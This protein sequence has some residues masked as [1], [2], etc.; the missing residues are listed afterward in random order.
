[1]TPTGTQ[2]ISKQ[3]TLTEGSWSP[4]CLA[5]NGYSYKWFR[6]GAQFQTGTFT[7]SS[8]TYTTQSADIGH[9]LTAQV[10]ACDTQSNCNGATATGSV[11]VSCTPTNSV[12]PTMNHSGNGVINTTLG[13][14]SNG[15][16]TAPCGALSYRYEWFRGS[17]QV[18]TASTYTTASADINSTITLKVQAYNANGSSSYV[19][20]SNT[21]Y[22][23]PAP[24]NTA[25]PTVSGT[26]TVGD[27]LTGN[28]GTWNQYGVSTTVSRQWQIC[29]YRNTVLSD[30]PLDYW[31]LGDAS[32]ASPTARDELELN[33][34]SYVGSPTLGAAP[35]ALNSDA[36]TAVAFNGNSYLS[37]SDP[38]QFGSANFTIEG[39]FKTSS[40]AG[41][42][43]IWESDYAGTPTQPQDVFLGLA[44]GKMMFQVEDQAGTLALV[45]S[46]LSYNNNAWHYV[47][48]VRNGNTFTVYVDG[49]SVGS[50]T[51]T[52]TLGSVDLSGSVPTI[53]DG[54]ST[55][56]NSHGAY[57]FGGS[58]DEVAV[59]QSALSS[60]RVS[61][62][63]NAGVDVTKGCANISGAT[64]S[65]YTLI[66]QDFG[67]KLRF[68]VSESNA[69]GTGPV[70]YSSLTGTVADSAPSTPTITY[71]AAPSGTPV[72]PTDTPVI[73]AS[74]PDSGDSDPVDY[75]FQ[76][77]NTNDPQFLSPLASSG[78]LRGTDN[79]T[80]PHGALSNGGT[81]ILRVQAR[82]PYQ[83]TAWSGQTTFKVSLPMLGSGYWPTWS[84]G[85]VT[86][87]EV[88]GNLM[89][90]LP[91]PSYPTATG[92]LS[93]SLTYN[94]QSSSNSPG[95][96]TGWTLGAGDAAA[97]PPVQLIDHSKDAQDPYPAAEI[98]WPDG[99]TD[100]YSQVGTSDT[101]TPDSKDGS[102]LTQNTDHSG[103]TL[104]A[105]DGT[106]Y[107]FDPATQPPNGVW[108]LTGA[109]TAAA[110]NGYGL[111]TYSFLNGLLHTL[112]YNQQSG[113]NDGETLTFNW[114]CT[115]YVLCVTGP[116]A[117]SGPSWD[118]AETNG[119]LS[120][121]DEVVGGSTH[122]Q[123]ALSYTGA[124][125][126]KIQNANDLDPAD[127]SPGYN[128]QHSLQLTY[129]G[130]KVACVID[131]PISGQAQT[132]QPSCAGG[133]NASESTW[134]FA[135]N[136][137]TSC[138]ALTPP[139][140]T[141]AVP[142]GS[143]NGCTTVTNPDQEPNGPGVT[144][145]YDSDG[146]P[147]ETDDARLGS[148]NQRITL[149]QYNAQNRLAW[150]EDE[151]GNPTDY[152]YD[153][154]N[155]V[156]LTQTAPSP[157][158]G[159]ARPI[160][161]DRY[162]EQTIG[163]ASTAGN[164][165][166]GLAGSYWTGANM[167]G[168]PATREND[169]TPTSSA[170]TFTL[171]ASGMTWPP[172][173]VGSG[174][175]SARFTGDI[176][177]PAT[178]D[179][180]FST[181][182]DG[183]TALTLGDT[184]LI[185]NGTSTSPPIH[186]AA[187]LHTLA[188]DYQHPSGGSANLTLKW[189]CADCS[190]ALS[191]AAVPLSDLFPA[192]ENQTSV[193]SPAGRISFQHYLNPASGQPD[194]ALTQPASGTNPNLI[195]SYVYD[196]LG[197]TA[198]QYMPQANLNA[199][200]NSTT[201]NL[202]S[203]PDQ[204]YETDYTYYPD[205]NPSTGAG[206]AAPPSA[207]GGGAAVDQYGQL[208]ETSNPDF[209]NNQTGAL[210]SIVTVYNT[211]GLPIAVT[212]GKGTSCLTYDGQNRLTSKTPAGDQSHP[213][214]YTYDPNGTQLTAA[215]ASG[216]VTDRY[217][218]ANRLID[219][220]DASDAEASYTYDPDG[221]QL[222][223]KA[224][225]GSLGSSTNYTTNYTYDAADELSSE[226]DPANNTYQFF[227][228]D[229]GNLRGTQYP[230]STPTF[231]WVDTN[232][233]GWIA[234]QYNRHGT[235]TS[236]T[237]TPPSDSNPLADY[238]YT[239]DAD[240]KKLS[241][242]FTTGSNSQTTGYSYDNAGRLNQVELP[243][244]TCRNY[245]Y[246]LDS[247]RTEIDNYPT[248]ACTGTPTNTT[249]Y[250]YD[251]TTTPGPDELTKTTAG[252]TTT[253]YTYTSDGQTSSQGTTNFTW[254]GF[255]RL[256]TA[257]VGSNTVTYTYDANDNLKTRSS[258]S[259]AS[260]T[261]YLIGD[262]FET[263]GSG[264]ITASYTDGPAGDLASFNGP[265]TGTSTYL[266]YD[267]HGNTAAEANTSGTLTASH[268]YDPF[269]APTDGVPSNTT[270]HRFVGR[271]DK[272]YDTTTGDILMGARPY[273]P[274]TGRF[275]SVDPIP[276]GSANNYDYAGQDPINGYDL[277]GQCW[278]GLCWVSHAAKAV[279]HAVARAYRRAT[280]LH[281]D[282][283]LLAGSDVIESASALALSG[284]IVFGCAAA[285]VF[286]GGIAL[287]AAPGCVLS[288]AAAATAGVILGRAAAADIER[289]LQRRRHHQHGR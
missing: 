195:T 71:P 206:T 252:S 99:S 182:N 57:Y 110:A 21:F 119:Q 231:S 261:N 139:K 205:Y 123:I 105:P 268:T 212:N 86:V 153:P 78:W 247:D 42:Q 236:N 72:V 223:R 150:T 48:A 62:H 74:A 47:A 111:L 27:T 199:T 266:Y 60:S 25:P 147:L 31:R 246:N 244:G 9:T 260:T 279:G 253:S 26:T 271:W 282:F 161:T 242:T 264:A 197:R 159:Q 272:Q 40:Q 69:D 274:N 255:G 256:A 124:Q 117:P 140:F 184:D 35:G 84:H 145:F 73:A 198:T 92:S 273:D 14:S 269:G 52:Q 122:K 32:G 120:E 79:W 229:R 200:L 193:V 220:V 259:P 118:Y 211:A 239:Y 13:V 18:G 39:W 64:G 91:T 80:V 7:S 277:D 181:I 235:I 179:Y 11:S 281:W 262:L 126:T 1:V 157:A 280:Q 192:W 162:D 89:L 33:D 245:S 30:S 143:V 225:T 209:N 96:P 204:N 218:E 237:T 2:P 240:G 154:L 174:A 83:D 278:T 177:I 3:L 23:V 173:A 188:L 116:D 46:S 107:L 5:I 61:A 270:I 189:S 53:G 238:A 250:T 37:L 165:L 254:D 234:D 276:G 202:T 185:D 219:T 275:L 258:S 133:G 129:N 12:A 45:T 121:V 155:N 17:T 168:Q 175:F 114:A 109:Q 170:T 56:S 85:P 54:Q 171:P 221:N 144:V 257:T 59:Y 194:Y 137:A 285:D 208:E 130:N 166:N 138:P 70:V 156:L 44:G 215:N 187:G 148:S 158:S 50:T 207:C 287:V 103:W 163:S 20:S 104:I 68:G 232:P 196:S 134:M 286:S 19:T 38:V 8:T 289:A 41:N 213:S 106:T 160:T 169:P 28:D 152:S 115:G 167:V 93:F 98:D 77:T 180:T 222:Q 97:S 227:Y 22:V 75:Q 6:D 151:D 201:G 251:P 66:G 88:N 183:S 82:D 81:Y 132:A 128:G 265:P 241:Q 135:Y 4:V 24:S 230:T 186:L 58:L 65:N 214:T 127:A 63:Y 49:A 288:A 210:H 164:P 76:V 67:N 131:G 36:N 233:D 243:N 55:S 190:P 102:Q 100:Y 267:A 29:G 178:G 10:I 283:V 176:N 16:W 43:Q 217:D 141:H 224:A 136:Q 216:T 95:M 108:P 15:T 51:P 284:T 146:R 34:G 149:Q 112:T 203:T 249:T 125:V 94:S 191:N 172:S 226:T 263:N 87:N 228:D 248:T 142:Q 113:Q 90:S 101:Y